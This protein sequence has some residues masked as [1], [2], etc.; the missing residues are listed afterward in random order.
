LRPS[1]FNASD[2]EEGVD[3]HSERAEA[4]LYQDRHGQDQDEVE[5]NDEEAVRVAKKMRRIFKK[6]IEGKLL[7]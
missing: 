7:P 6:K 3:D 2:K 4:R 5:S 1:K